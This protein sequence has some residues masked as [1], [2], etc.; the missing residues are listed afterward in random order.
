MKNSR[1]VRIIK[2]LI[3][4]EILNIKYNKMQLWNNNYFYDTKDI[5]IIVN[6]KKY[7]LNSVI[8]FTSEYIRKLYNI[9]WSYEYD[10][11]K[12]ITDVSTEIWELFL[13]YLY[14][15]YIEGY[16]QNVTYL[17]NN[18]TIN[19]GD[20]EVNNLIELLI[21]VD[22]M[23]IPKISYDISY[24][25]YKNF[26]IKFDSEYIT[27]IRL[28]EI[29]SIL[30]VINTDIID[31]Y[32]TILFYEKPIYNIDNNSWSINF[33][34][35]YKFPR[36][37]Y[38]LLVYLS[39]IKQLD[40]KSASVYLNFNI[41]SSHHRPLYFTSNNVLLSSLK[42]KFE[43]SDQYIKIF[44]NVDQL[45]PNNVSIS[46]KYFYITSYALIILY[47]SI[48]YLFSDIVY[49]NILS[50]QHVFKDNFRLNG[51]DTIYEAIERDIKIL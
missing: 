25:F 30:S 10:K 24:Y 34:L 48:S 8:L 2:R 20:I 1:K 28:N 38:Y 46:K 6:N 33:S 27:D 23:I 26:L 40:N 51:D 45:F 16:L 5:E 37:L 32:D 44:N 35:Y 36:V 4:K 17:E 19:V 47:F 11:N 42:K 7:E 31:I 3:L 18:N 21:F 22:R 50:L 14:S 12:E 29:E 13:N 39:Q 49:E 15:I 41:V 43:I 9:K